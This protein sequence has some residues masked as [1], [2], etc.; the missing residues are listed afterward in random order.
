M[1]FLIFSRAKKKKTRRKSCILSFLQSWTALTKKKTFVVQWRNSDSQRQRSH[2]DPAPDTDNQKEKVTG[3]I[4]NQKPQRRSS[5][6]LWPAARRVCSL[7]YFLTSCA[8][9]QL[10]AIVLPFTIAEHFLN[11]QH[12][13]KGEKKKKHSDVFI[14]RLK[15]MDT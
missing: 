5:L 6:K 12:K 13:P 2:F 7:L 1:P 14:H 4:A 8:A 9:L 11:Y 3:R 15:M 10:H